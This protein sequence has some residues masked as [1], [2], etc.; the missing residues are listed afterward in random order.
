[1]NLHFS[2]KEMSTAAIFTAIT[3]ILAQISIPLPF[4]PVP[5]TFQ[6]FAVY[7]SAI[8]LGSRLGTLS[9]I[10]YLLLG[11]IGIPVFASF[12]GGLQ[13]IVGPS[14]GFLISYPIISYIIGKISEKDLNPIMSI[15]GL[16]V[17]LIICYSIG[18]IQFHFVTNVPIQKSIL[19][20]VAPFVPLDTAKII[21]AYLAGHKIKQSLLK[22]NLIKC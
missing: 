4:T 1:M 6:I 16:I 12:T 14:G 21:V 7:I 22:A 20:C 18:T 15:L 8:I 11:A 17:S 19:L 5:I 3:A 2:V 13:T 10:I 9:Q